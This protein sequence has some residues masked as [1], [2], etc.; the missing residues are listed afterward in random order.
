MSLY[1][2]TK[3]NKIIIDCRYWVKTVN[4]Y[5]ILTI[6]STV[7]VLCYKSVRSISNQECF[8]DI[9]NKP[10]KYDLMKFV[11]DIDDLSNL[12]SWLWKDY[13]MTKKNTDSEKQY[14]EVLKILRE[15][16][17][18]VADKYDLCFVED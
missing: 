15:K 4:D 17:K 1:L 5:V 8:F 12:N 18:T 11:E 9:V 7:D 2:R 10:F 3:D 14:E 16:F 13:P 6:S